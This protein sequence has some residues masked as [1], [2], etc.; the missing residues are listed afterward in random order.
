ME[1]H[2]KKLA[3]TENLKKNFSV[4]PPPPPPTNLKE[5]KAKH[6]GPYYWLKGK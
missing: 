4:P 3:N 6:L 5:I 1:H 2:G